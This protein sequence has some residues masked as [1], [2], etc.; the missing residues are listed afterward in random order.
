MSQQRTVTCF[1][2]PGRISL[3]AEAGTGRGVY[4]SIAAE[5]CSPGPSNGAPHRPQNRFSAGL[6][7]PQDGH[8]DGSGAP[9][10]PQNFIPARLSAWHRKHLMSCLHRVVPAWCMNARTKPSPKLSAVQL[11]LAADQVRQPPDAAASGLT[12]CE[13]FSPSVTDLTLASSRPVISGP[14]SRGFITS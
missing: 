14:P 13:F 8:A 1:I 2:S 6:A 7:A 12:Q 4:G 11:L 10:S 5:S 9:H 3:G